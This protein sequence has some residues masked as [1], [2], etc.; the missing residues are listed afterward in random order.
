MG[1][2]PPH[3]RDGAVLLVDV[4]VS[5]GGEVIVARPVVEPTWVDVDAGWVVR[6]VSAALADPA[7]PAGRRTQ[8]EQSLQRTRAVVGDYVAG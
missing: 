6:R 2:W 5:P 8:L 1:P 4:T 7:T 3:V